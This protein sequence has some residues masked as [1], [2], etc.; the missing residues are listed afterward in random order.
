[1]DAALYE[2]LTGFYSDGLPLDGLPDG[3]QLVRSVLDNI[4]RILNSRSGSLKHLPDYGI[5][6]LSM[7][8]KNLPSSA[9]DLRYFMRKTLLKYEPRLRNLDIRLT[10]SKDNIMALCYQLECEI[11]NAGAVVIDTYFMPEGTVSVK[12]SRA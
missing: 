9:H 1:M 8:Y 7:V 11:E 4:Q 5:P 2:K 10:E 12:R 6:D 3:F